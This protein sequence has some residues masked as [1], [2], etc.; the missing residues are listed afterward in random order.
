MGFFLG[1]MGDGF[2]DEIV[3]LAL[4]RLQRDVFEC[5]LQKCIGGGWKSVEDENIPDIPSVDCNVP[6]RTIIG[7]KWRIGVLKF[8]WF[9]A[10]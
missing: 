2:F 1:E 6:F 3:G 9:G 8:A 4:R 10:V 5:F 7:G